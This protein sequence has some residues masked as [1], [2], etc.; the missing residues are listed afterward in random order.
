MQDRGAAP[1][2]KIL[3]IARRI[4]EAQIDLLR[5]RD[6][7]LQFLSDKLREPYYESRASRRMKV[8]MLCKLLGHD[9]DIPAEMV[10]PFMTAT[11]Q[12][13]EKFSLILLQE[14]KQLRAFDRYERRA[15]SRRKFAIRD[16][17]GASARVRLQ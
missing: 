11:P 4:A 14:I 7:R 12:G 13:P 5:V 2:P 16:L 3:Q 15:L 10:A 17:D 1:L 8:S 6:A 9:P